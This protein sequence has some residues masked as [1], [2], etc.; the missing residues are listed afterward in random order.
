MFSDDHSELFKRIR[1]GDYTGEI[2]VDPDTPLE[3]LFSVPLYAGVLCLILG[4]LWLLFSGQAA[5]W[6]MFKYGL[7]LFPIGA[8]LS[9]QVEVDYR[10]DLEAK[11]VSLYRRIFRWESKTFVCD[12]SQIEC[13]ADDTSVSFHGEGSR[14]RREFR[15]GLVLVLKKGTLL[16]VTGLDFKDHSAVSEHG[17]RLAD[18][19]EL[20]YCSGAGKL[21]VRRTAQGPQLSYKPSPT[22][23]TWDSL[24]GGCAGVVLVAG[25]TFG[26]I[27]RAVNGPRP[28]KSS[29]GY[30]APKLPPRG[31]DLVPKLDQSGHQFRVHIENEGTETCRTPF[32]VQVDVDGKRV[33]NEKVF[34]RRTD[35]LR[36]TVKKGKRVKMM[37]DVGDAVKELDESNNVKTVDLKF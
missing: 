9:T 19:L 24:T 16:R 37:V 11:T 1:Q 36:F 25:L 3:Q 10:M 31:V 26:L 17:Q 8:F 32:V 15:S 2:V 35:R 28:P 34:Q 13:V 22:L 20:P 4:G 33:V 27:D 14:R 5:A 21:Q 18:L 23:S 6:S 12:F 30:H 7:L 29:S